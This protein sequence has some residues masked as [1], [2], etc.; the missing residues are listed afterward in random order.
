M[1]MR[2]IAPVYSMDSAR[3][4]KLLGRPERLF[5]WTPT[6]HAA[7]G[8]DHRTKVGDF[9]I[10]DRVSFALGGYC[11]EPQTRTGIVVAFIA[12]PAREDGASCLGLAA[13]TIARV[14][15]Q[16]TCICVQVKQLRHAPRDAAGEAALA[17]MFD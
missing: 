1:I 17:A 2:G 6:T 9:A 13:P 15:C 14:M 5:P 11:R 4:A 8:P 16:G 7:A 12:A 3:A 10:G